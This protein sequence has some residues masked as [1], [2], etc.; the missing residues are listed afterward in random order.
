MLTAPFTLA[1]GGY[2]MKSQA[3]E[4]VLAAIQA[5][6]RGE[7]YV[8]RPVAARLGHNLFPDPASDVSD[9]QLPGS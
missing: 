5:T 6:L 1:R 2:V 3:T 4:T 9:F 8:G 7:L